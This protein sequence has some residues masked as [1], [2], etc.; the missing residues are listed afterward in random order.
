VRLPGA[1]VVHVE[2][3]ALE[4]AVDADADAQQDLSPQPQGRLGAQGG[5]KRR[6]SPSTTNPVP[7]RRSSPLT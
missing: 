4:V 5:V 6:L 7:C 3:V 2:R 1:A